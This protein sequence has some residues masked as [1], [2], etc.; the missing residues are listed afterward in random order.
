MRK[1]SEKLGAPQPLVAAARGGREEGRGGRGLSFRG[2]GIK[3]RHAT[4]LVGKSSNTSSPSS[5][6][7]NREIRKLKALEKRG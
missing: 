4:N 2:E 6:A 5:A 7:H 1:T 3:I